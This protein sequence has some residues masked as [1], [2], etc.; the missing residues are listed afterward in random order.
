MTAEPT[1]SRFRDNSLLGITA[2][3]AAAVVAGTICSLAKFSQPVTTSVLAFAAALP[4]AI[5]LQI[6]NRQR[7]ASVDTARIRD[8]E[9]RRPVGLVVMLLAA[10][11]LLIDSVAGG[12]LGGFNDL[13]ATS[14]I[15]INV[16]RVVSPIFTSL[17]I[18]L[19]GLGY[20]LGSSYASHYLAKHP[21]GWTTAAVGCA[22]VGREL[23]VF[24]LS[25]SGG[26]KVVINEVGGS[27]TRFLLI[28][29][30]AY[31]CILVVCMTGVWFGV[32]R[33]D[34]FLAK[35][36][37][38]VERKIPL[39]AAARPTQASTPNQTVPVTLPPP[40]ARDRRLE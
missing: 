19:L 17:P 15:D 16:A 3:L 7:D 22:L 12:I 26:L 1:T 38:R 21:Y 29:V 23:A 37:A 31:L 14:K 32:R 13:V 2:G 5:D 34:E 35:K 18:M 30:A 8:G 25:D 40:N 11:I 28:E 33:H 4:A 10:A 6:K 9:L 20:F 39:A 24:A 27:L 36:L